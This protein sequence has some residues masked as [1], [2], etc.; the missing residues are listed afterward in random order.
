M[1]TAPISTTE[2]AIEDLVNAL[3]GI[4]GTGQY[5]LAMQSVRRAY[6]LPHREPQANFP[7]LGI[8]NIVANDIAQP[9]GIAEST[10]DIS[11]EGFVYAD[12][13]S[14]ATIDAAST[15]LQ[16]IVHDVDYAINL[17]PRRGGFAGHTEITRYTMNTVLDNDRMSF[18]HVM[19][20]IQMVAVR[21]VVGD[22]RETG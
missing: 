4:D 1:P 13:T 15:E 9:T 14:A 18:A 20:D 2:S 3:K 5:H 11:L 19:M 8:A 12:Q 17:D 21:H 6:L 7:F 10:V 16:K 22:M